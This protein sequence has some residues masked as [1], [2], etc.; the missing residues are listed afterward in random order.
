MVLPGT[1]RQRGNRQARFP[2]CRGRIR[3]RLHVIEHVGGKTGIEERCHVIDLQLAERYTQIIDIQSILSDALDV[4]SAQVHTDTQ[5]VRKRNLQDIRNR[6]W[7]RT[8]GDEFPS[9]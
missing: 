7:T 6:A 8:S 5:P 3:R 1:Y 4:P 9:P 2:G